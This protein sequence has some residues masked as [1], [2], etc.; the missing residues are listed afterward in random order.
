MSDIPK[1]CEPKDKTIIIN[2]ISKDL[3]N[4]INS[5]EGKKIIIDIIKNK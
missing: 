3:L 5:E 4:L 2:T 1:D